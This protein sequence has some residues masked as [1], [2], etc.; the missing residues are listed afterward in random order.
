MSRPLTINVT[1]LSVILP[2]V[3]VVLLLLFTCIHVVP[4]GY[5][6]VVKLFGNVRSQPLPEGLHF[7]NPL[8][9][10]IDFNVRL[11]SATAQRAEGSTSD[12][13]EVYEDITVNY[14]FDPV[15]APVI[16]NTIGNY[17]EIEKRFV[18]PALY[19]SFK[20]VSSQYTAEQLVTARSTVS[21]NIVKQ[22]Q[23]KLTKY[24]INVSDIN[25]QNFKFDQ[26][27][28]DAVQQKVVAGQNRLTAE[29]NLET[30]KIS[31]QQKVVEA[32]GQAKAIAIQAQAIQQQ[33][34]A[35]YVQL[36]AIEKWDGQ[37]P[38]QWAGGA[39]P[40]VNFSTPQTQHK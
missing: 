1:R 38:T 33:G 26:K 28:A 23:S 15:Y 18:V 27:F 10:V 36:R 6:G 30:A 31:A 17:D 16:Y 8:A 14:S 12:L 19:E 34:G 5:Q 2:V 24:H 21:Q 22:L 39:L 35:E 32:D 40:F 4:A 3:V 29:Q 25:V 13:Q 11:Q 20:A 37:L 7:L 9:T